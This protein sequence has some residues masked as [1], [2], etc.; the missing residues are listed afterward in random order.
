MGKISEHQEKV[1][2]TLQQQNK[3][4]EVVPKCTFEINKCALDLKR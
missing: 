4:V 2:T 3:A 1:T